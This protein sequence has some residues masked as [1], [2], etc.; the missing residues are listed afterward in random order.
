[1]NEATKLQKLE[2]YAQQIREAFERFSAEPP[3]DLAPARRELVERIGRLAA[4]TEKTAHSPVRIGIVGEF[5]AGKTLLLGSLIGYA[6]GLPVSELPTTGNV[7]ALHFQVQEDLQ[8]TQLGPF[9]LEYLDGEGVEECLA[10]VLKETRARA[11]AA[12]LRPALKEQLAQLTPKQLVALEQWCKEAW[13]ASNNP[14]LRYVLRELVRFVRCYARC[15]PGMCTQPQE[16]TVPTKTAQHGLELAEPPRD[17]QTMAFDELPEAPGPISSPPE[18]D[19]LTFNQI[20]DTFPLI[21]RVRVEVKV[22]RGIWDFSA[23]TGGNAFVLLDFPGLGAAS[24]ACV[25]RF[26]AYANW[27]KFRRS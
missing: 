20:R 17:I 13:S 16:F 21:R 27:P 7:T 6:D 12:Q 1:M 26:S 15:G 11:D 24:P 10:Y 23:L 3:S 14:G 19:G 2:Q 25:T 5:S 18:S 4:E 9:T 22:S 8:T